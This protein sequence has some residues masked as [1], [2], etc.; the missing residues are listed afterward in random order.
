MKIY[1]PGCEVTI[2]SLGMKNLKARVALFQIGEGDIIRYYLKYWS[3]LE[4][5][6]NYFYEDEIECG[7]VKH[8]IGFHDANK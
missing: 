8:T 7:S 5:K 2:K 1:K 3:G 6:E 4:I